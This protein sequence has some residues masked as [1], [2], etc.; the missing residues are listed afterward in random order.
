MS[1]FVFLWGALGAP[2]NKKKLYHGQTLFSY[3]LFSEAPRVKSNFTDFGF[4]NFFSGG[5]RGIFEFFQF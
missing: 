5:L 2:K 1:T 3:F 4:L